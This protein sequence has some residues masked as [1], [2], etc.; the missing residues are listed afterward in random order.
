MNEVKWNDR[1]MQRFMPFIKNYVYNTYYLCST[2]LVHILFI[3]HWTLFF[4]N[5]AA[6]FKKLTNW[7]AIRPNSIKNYIANGLSDSKKRIAVEGAPHFVS[8]FAPR[9]LGTAQKKG[10]AHLNFHMCVVTIRSLGKIKDGNTNILSYI[11]D[12]SI[13]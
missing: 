4:H 11:S 5:K 9:M 2:L 10:V 13:L 1:N 12:L 6:E 3:H 7:D 8:F